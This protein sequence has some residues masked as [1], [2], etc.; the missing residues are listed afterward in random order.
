MPGGAEPS[1][2]GLAGGHGDTIRSQHPSECENVS[3]RDR[4]PDMKPVD[5][6]QELFD[7]PGHVRGL[8]RSVEWPE[9]ALGAVGS[10]SPVLRTMVRAAL[11]SGF[12]IIIHWGPARVAVYND[13][14]APL[15]GDKHPA[16]LGRPAQ[17]TWPEAWDVVGGRLDEVIKHGRTVHHT[18][19]HRIL[20][21]H[22]NPEEC[23]F[24]FSHSPIED[25]D[26]TRVGVL[27]IATETTDTVLYRRR[28]RVIQDLGAVS[29]T[30][31]GGAAETCRAVLAVLGTVRESMPFAVAILREDDGAAERV[32]DYGL[33]PES[34][35]EPDQ[36]GEGHGYV[37]AGRP[38][39]LV[40]IERVLS[41]GQPEEV[42]G[43]R[44]AFPGALLPG[45]LGPLTP[46][47]AVLLP[48]WVTGRAAPIGVLAVGVNPYR[49]LDDHYRRFFALVA[50]QV[51]VAL[52]DTLAYQVQKLRGQVLADLDR[53]KMEFFQNVSHELRTPLT[54]LLA[55]LQNLLAA[56]ADRPA[57]DRQDLQAAVRAAQRLNTMVDALLDF[58]GAEAR[59]LAPDRQP[60]DLAELTGQT[61]SMF[62]AT[63]EHTGLTF[64]VRLPDGPTTAPVDR[65]MWATIVS[66][67]LANAVKYTRH[68]CIEVT[69]T[70][71]DTDVELTVA[72][73]GPGIDP[74]QQEL[75]FD[76]FHRAPDS[77]QPGAGIG[78]SVVADLVHAHDGR[79]EL[80]SAP[81]RG[82]TFTVTMPLLTT[83]PASSDE[84]VV[85]TAG[86][87]WDGRPRVLLVEDDTDLRQFLTRLLARDGWQV[88]SYPDAERALGELLNSPDDPPG[89]VITDVMLP[90]QSGL[91][92]IGQLREHPATRRTPMIILTA[93][94]GADATAEGLSA[95]A[96][97]YVT[98]PFSAPELLARAHAAYQLARL[99]ESAVHDAQDRS[100]HLRVGL[101]SSRTIGT[102]IGILMTA[103]HLTAEVAFRLLVT[104]SQNTNRKLRDIAADIATT[105]QLPLRPALTHELLIRVTGPGLSE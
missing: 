29:T 9:T 16:A 1:T 97:D 79:I 66:N 40:L 15:I 36:P 47:Q 2:I 12:P 13:A 84:P 8:L 93:R 73:T 71:T 75:V 59:T 60:T 94:H 25:L 55:P 23:Y 102:A 86:P 57:A 24:N 77:D 69:L 58:T 63:A 88:A 6:E 78:L 22:G 18:D 98:K 91:D 90:G 26:G 72:D 17:D 7:G 68:G 74:A 39:P 42:S 53:A 92:L 28:M 32:A 35:P 4:W 70:A 33:A 31:A 80:D 82:S 83:D 105:G 45:P 104:A 38:D 96:D 43:L 61:A 11:A 21:R 46:D 5:A 10:W 100:E 56:S 44:E 19:E 51:R 89:L 76:R 34:A 101:D 67:L 50:R 37:P 14:F 99:R 54:V 62:R 3:G 27:S 48:L 49:P 103:H 41:T 87:D 65:T 20:H 95:G 52:D 85:A 30:G 64:Q 81:G